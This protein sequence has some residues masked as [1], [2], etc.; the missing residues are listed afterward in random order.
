MIVPRP[1]EGLA[2][3][4]L[5]LPALP[6]FLSSRDPPSQRPLS[7][8]SPKPKA[9]EL[10]WNRDES[11]VKEATWS[12]S[13]RRSSRFSTE[14]RPNSFALVKISFSRATLHSSR[15]STSLR[16]FALLS[17]LFRPSLPC[18]ITLSKEAS[19]CLLRLVRTRSLN[20][21]RS[22]VPALTFSW[23]GLSPP[24]LGGISLPQQALLCSSSNST[25]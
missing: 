8:P 6:T 21:S 17:S 24:P 1:T 2:E 23:M 15:T 11:L 25:R 4:G 12:V 9:P 18:R 3:L 14:T 7:P 22:V 13:F 16:A 10:G 5:A 20:T 19:S